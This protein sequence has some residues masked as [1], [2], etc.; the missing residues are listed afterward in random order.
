MIGTAF[1]V[2]QYIEPRGRKLVTAVSYAMIGW[3]TP[4]VS[5]GVDRIKGYA[6]GWAAGTP[7]RTK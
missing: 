7:L 6:A 2:S 4:A 5:H 3:I 1:A